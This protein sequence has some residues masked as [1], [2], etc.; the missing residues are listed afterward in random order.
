MTTSV[1][2][3]TAAVVSDES[4]PISAC[5]TVCEISSSRTK[6]KIVTWASPR[7]P[8]RRTTISSSR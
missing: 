6:S 1:T 3:I 2:V 5:P 8:L 7:L 4:S